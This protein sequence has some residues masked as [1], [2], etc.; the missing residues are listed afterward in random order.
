[1]KQKAEIEATMHVL[2]QEEIV[3]AAEAEAQILEQVIY[4]VQLEH[5]H[6]TNYDIHEQRTA[7]DRVGEYV[8]EQA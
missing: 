3:V 7:A 5:E 8:N 6:S 1:M 4:D 2:K